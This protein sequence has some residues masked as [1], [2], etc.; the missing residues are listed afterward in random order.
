MSRPVT[1]IQCDSMAC[2]FTLLTEP[3]NAKPDINDIM[4]LILLPDEVVVSFTGNLRTNM[5]TAGKNLESLQCPKRLV[6]KE[7]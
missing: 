6:S 5:S 2:A 4:T 1:R 7:Y 3:L